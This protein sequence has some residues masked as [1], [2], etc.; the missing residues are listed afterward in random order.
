MNE[1]GVYRATPMAMSWTVKGGTTSN[2]KA[3]R[4]DRGN[5]LPAGFYL[6]RLGTR[7]AT[8]TTRIVLLP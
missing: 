5:M 1:V 4:D 7:D 2:I 6:I 8:R 3:A